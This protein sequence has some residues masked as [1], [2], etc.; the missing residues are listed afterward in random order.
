M[1]VAIYNKSGKKTDNLKLNDK[2]YGQPVN[3]A[4][5]QQFVKMYLANQRTGT[6]STKNRSEVAGGGQKPWRQ[7]GTGRAR[8]GSIRSPIFK[9]GGVIFGPRPRDYSYSLPKK[10]KK[11]ALLA[12]IN[13]RL[14]DNN[15]M[16]IDSIELESIKTKDFAKIIKTLK[17]DSNKVLVV[18]D[19]LDEKIKKSAR[20]MKNV[21]VKSS[22]AV[23]AY[24]VLWHDKLLITKK[25]IDDI[26]KRVKL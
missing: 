24:D 6:A 26:N 18:V 23:C 2:L 8:T 21:S 11:K 19:E 10:I 13:S 17:L 14:K 20:N 25:A 5:L 9:G 22:G 1:E 3:E 4:I 12:A 16:V 7:K 15:L